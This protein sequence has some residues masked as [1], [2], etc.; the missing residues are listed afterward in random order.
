MIYLALTAAVIA[1]G[2]AIYL[3]AICRQT[4]RDL[5]DMAR[6]H[7]TMMERFNRTSEV[8]VE[9]CDALQ[10]LGRNCYVTNERGHRV[11]YRNASPE[12]RAKAEGIVK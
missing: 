10:A 11:R 8:Y 5:C 1:T 3:N 9:A 7:R 6:A 4:E 2:A 12:A